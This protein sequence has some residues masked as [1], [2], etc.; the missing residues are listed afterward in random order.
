LV[1]RSDIGR[2]GTR[3][4]PIGSTLTAIGSPRG[5]AT[6]DRNRKAAVRS[7]SPRRGVAAMNLD[8]RLELRDLL[9]GDQLWRREIDQLLARAASDPDVGRLAAD[10]Q[11]VLARLREVV[12]EHLPVATPPEAV[13]YALTHASA[14]TIASI[15]DFCGLDERHDSRDL[16]EVRRL[17]AQHVADGRLSVE[18]MFTCPRCGFPVDITELPDQPIAVTCIHDSCRGEEIIDPATAR[19]VFVNSNRDPTLEGWV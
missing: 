10:L 3:H 9:Q 1:G 18:C 5:T 11:P 16:H 2:K 6:I 14:F 8:E 19:A 13:E 17:L 15:V 7:G 4:R 12:D